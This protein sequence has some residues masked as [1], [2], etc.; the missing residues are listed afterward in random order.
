MHK[1]SAPSRM[2]W[3]IAAVLTT[4]SAQAAEAPQPAIVPSAP[5]ALVTAVSTFGIDYIVGTARYVVDAQTPFVNPA[6][7]ATLGA[8]NARLIESYHDSMRDARFGAAQF[9]ASIN[10]AIAAGTL[11]ASSTG[12]GAVIAIPTGIAASKMNDMAR[13]YLVA[14][15]QARASAALD[16]GLT[17]MTDDQRSVM[18]NLLKAGRYKEAGDQFEKTTGA[19]STMRVKLAGDP[20]AQK[21]FDRS[22][23]AAMSQGSVA[24]IRTAADAVEKVGDVEDQFVGFTRNFSAFGK[25]TDAALQKLENST[26]EL[27]GQINEVQGQFSELARSSNANGLQIALI[28]QVLFDQ[29]PPSV[30]LAMLKNNALP[31]L[32][33]SQRDTL[34][35][36]LSIEVKQQEIVSTVTT[37]VGYARDLNT[38]MGAFGASDPG[39]QKAIS[40]GNAA[41]QALFQAFS[42]N[43]LGAVASVAGLFGG[44]SPPDPMAAHMKEIMAAFDGVNKRL[45]AVL[46][47]QRQTLQAVLVLTHNLNVLRR[48]THARFDRVDFE[49]AQLKS[50]Q[51]QALWSDLGVCVS[52]Y[53]SQDADLI[54]GPPE[55]P[56]KRRYDENNRRFASFDAMRDYTKSYG[57]KAYECAEYLNNLFSTFR[58]PN[59]L[60]GNPLSLANAEAKLGAHAGVPDDPP[61]TKPA[62]TENP[63]PGAITLIEY[64]MPALAYYKSRLYEPSRRVFQYGWLTSY[65]AN[66]GW[67]GLANAYAMLTRPSASAKVLHD[68]IAAMDTASQADPFRP[69]QGTRSLLG[70]RLQNYLCSDTTVYSEQP[71][72]PNALAYADE[73][74][75]Q[76]AE[77]FL[78]EPILRDQVG[79]LVKYALFIAGPRDLVKGGGASPPYTL[80]E[81]A[82]SGNDPYGRN[83]L[84]RALT[85]IDVA[86]AQQSMLYGDMTAY[87]VVNL[88]WDEQTRRLR[89]VAL[90]EAEKDAF[91]EANRLLRNTNNPWLR[92]NVAMI[93]LKRSQRGCDARDQGERCQQNKLLYE[94]ALDRFFAVRDGKYAP[95]D[96]DTL[97]AGS[98]TLR[99]AFEIHAEAT[100]LVKDQMQPGDVAGTVPRTLVLSLDGF[101]LPL[102]NLSDWKQGA[103]VYPALMHDR[104]ADRERVANRL[105]GYAALERLDSAQRQALLTLLAN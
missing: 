90:S 67:G 32:T 79:E 62:Q 25:K 103:L 91:E 61:V 69:C 54:G 11:G 14:N 100:F 24:A 10:L 49:L 102:P 50:L 59:S 5:P 93:I 6:T 74:A 30:K 78:S 20:E 55:Q 70:R 71:D 58:E 80:A 41:A 18:D 38:I 95:I 52:A 29:Q 19:L 21:L 89:K 85:V 77:A 3:A 96:A 4:T 39:L 81:V 23:T 44:G 33:T 28:Q 104:L 98:I 82:A 53:Q 2:T 35:K 83:L 72:N 16:A 64:D 86:I 34:T 66:V 92:R 8:A 37:V 17:R 13:D 63:Q 47:L 97:A 101:E 40:Y 42:G 27:S 57:G 65:A 45:D 94:L 68:R 76:R 15:V 43:Y 105:A 12:V 51:H 87:F 56:L 9:H 88:L 22:M 48:E 60:A 7:A 99:Q 73:L 75:R 36:T 46:E 26:R 31:G 1:L 84:N